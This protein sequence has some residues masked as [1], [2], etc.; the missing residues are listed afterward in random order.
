MLRNLLKITE[1]V[2]NRAGTSITS[3]LHSPHF[4]IFFQLKQYKQIQF[5]LVLGVQSYTL[6]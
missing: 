6:W 4:L 3:W 5:V 2:S 1:L